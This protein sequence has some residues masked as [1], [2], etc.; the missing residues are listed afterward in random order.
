VIE[1][2]LYKNVRDFWRDRNS[3]EFREL[4]RE[5]MMEWRRENTS[6]RVRRPTRID[7]ARLL[8]TERNK[9]L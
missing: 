8:V 6:V 5:R 4:R 7:R 2:N 1:V 9:V 3:E